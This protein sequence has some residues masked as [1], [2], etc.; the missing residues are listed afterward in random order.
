MESNHT[1]LQNDFT[2]R[3]HRQMLK[4][5][6]Y[7]FQLNLY[8][9]ETLFAY[10]AGF[11]PAPPASSASVVTIPLRTKLLLLSC[12]NITIFV[13]WLLNLYTELPYCI[14]YHPHFCWPGRNRTYIRWLTV[15]RN[16]PYTTG[17]FKINL[18]EL[19]RPSKYTISLSVKSQRRAFDF[20]WICCD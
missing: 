7:T 16:N 10:S 2:D 5:P 3:L 18:P 9:C 13:V 15:I 6:K 19:H 1:L 8:K 4:L 12:G 17:Q 14:N 20:D 11:E